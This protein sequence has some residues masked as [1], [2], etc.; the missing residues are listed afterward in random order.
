VLREHHSVSFILRT[1][2]ESFP[3]TAEAK[4]YFRMQV[5]TIIPAD[6]IWYAH[7]HAL[8]CSLPESCRNAAR[9]LWAETVPIKKVTSL[10]NWCGLLLS[11]WVLE[12]WPPPF[13][14]V[15]SAQAI[16]IA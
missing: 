10:R 5:E 2:I 12:L 11:L 13:G 1:L 4:T 15:A 9:A 8:S 6:G 16:R 7:E 3:E 14:P